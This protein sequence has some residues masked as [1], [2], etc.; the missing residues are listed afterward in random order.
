MRVTPLYAALLALLFVV[1]SVR[2]LRMRRGL[3]IAIGD[4]GDER[5]LRAM[6]VHSNFAEYA[7]LALL[8]MYLLDVRGLGEGTLHTLGA[9]LLAGRISHAWGV[10]HVQERYAFRV[11]GMALTI[12]VLVAEASMLLVGWLQAH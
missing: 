3:G 1:L 2:A 6:R 9:C 4:A 7:P 8:L 12:G 10:S 5:M 11:F